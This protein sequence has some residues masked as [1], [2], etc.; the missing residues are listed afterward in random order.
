MRDPMEEESLD[1]IRENL[2]NTYSVRHREHGTVISIY[3]D[4]DVDP[5]QGRFDVIWDGPWRIALQIYNLNE[6]F[7]HPMPSGPARDRW[8]AECVEEHDI[9]RRA[10]LWHS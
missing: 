5:N 3:A 10:I 6:A 8:R 1:S 7:L 9:I 2:R 4:E